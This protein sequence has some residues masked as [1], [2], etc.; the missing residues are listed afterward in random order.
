MK[1]LKNFSVITIM[2]LAITMVSCE[3]EKQTEFETLNKDENLSLKKAAKKSTKVQ[4]C[5]ITGNGDYVLIEVSAN[6]V[7]AH[8]AHGDKLVDADG[9][10]FTAIE[11]CTG[12]MDDCND[13]DASIHPG[14]VEIC[15]DGID[16]NCNGQVDED[17]T[18]TFTDDRDNQEYE[19]VEI[20]NQIWMAENLKYLPAVVG[21]DTKSY[22][23]PYY[24]VYD[25]NGTDLTAA[26]ATENYNTYGVLY[27]WPAALIS[28]P[29]G[30]H[31]PSDSEWIELTNYLID[32]GYGYGG[33][34]Y[35]IGKSMAATSGWHISLDR[36]S[37]VVG[38]NQATNNSSGFTALP[39]GGRANNGEFGGLGFNG[40]WWSSSEIWSSRAWFLS[41]SYFFDDVDWSNYLKEDG[42][43]VRCIKD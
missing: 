35:D 28:C 39:G 3:K 1:L 27:N 5:H 42:F 30:W 33:S 38:N 32:N 20:G 21:P 24:Y 31:L 19:I 15:G 16:N 34:G 43:S 36:P 37:A 10:G 12:S 25:Y 29:S 6:A 11:S 8:L 17:C 23:D 18:E 22:T 14:A 4:L 2:L 40:Y 9:D 13:L 41:L 7:K 26:K